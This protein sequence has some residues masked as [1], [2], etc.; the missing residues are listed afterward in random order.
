MLPT[1][2]GVDST[3]FIL[4]QTWQHSLFRRLLTG[5]NR[6]GR[7]ARRLMNRRYPKNTDHLA[8]S[9]AMASLGTIELITSFKLKSRMLEFCH[10]TGVMN[11]LCEKWVPS[12]PQI[13][14]F[15]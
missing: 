15:T 14:H 9:E 13:A 8:D 1:K 7:P 12:D 4:F 3:G 11:A 2:F 6:F 5:R 10:S